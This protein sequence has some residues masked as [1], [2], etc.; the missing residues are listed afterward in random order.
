M[1]EIHVK[2]F[3]E[4]GM[5]SS[6]YNGIRVQERTL[7]A[8]MDTLIKTVLEAVAYAVGRGIRPAP[9]A[10]EFAQ[11]YRGGGTVWWDIVMP[12][13]LKFV[14]IDFEITDAD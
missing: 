5:W 3:F 4:E 13:P 9:D 11:V 8:S 1:K 7:P 10:A 12:Q 6:D 14:T 2:S